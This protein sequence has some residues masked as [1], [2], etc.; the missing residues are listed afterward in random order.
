MPSLR[1]IVIKEWYLNLSSSIFAELSHVEN[2]ELI[3]NNIT[4]LHENSFKG[5]VRLKTLYSLNHIE[6]I[7]PG[8]FTGKK[9]LPTNYNFKN[10]CNKQ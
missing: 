2:M 9:C 10:N 3:R 8:V 7:S 6:D 4:S 5:L 1:K